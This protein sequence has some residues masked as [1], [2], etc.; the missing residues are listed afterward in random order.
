MP[1]TYKSIGT[2]LGSTASTTIYA[3]VSGTALVNG[4]VFSN[5]N[6]SSGTTVTLNLVKGSTS[7]SL[8]TNGDVPIKSSLQALDAPI[9]LENSNTLTAT[10]GNSGFL[11][12]VVSVLEI[13]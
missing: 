7:Y 2:I 6:E 9:V 8:L 13:T 3:G 12:A 5:I 10:A 1:E 4:V 11:H